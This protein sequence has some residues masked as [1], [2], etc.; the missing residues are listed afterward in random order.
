MQNFIEDHRGQITIV[1][2]LMIFVTILIYIVAVMPILT[3][4]LHN[5]TEDTTSAYYIEDE[6]VRIV[7]KLLPLLILLTIVVSI[8]VYTQPTYP[9]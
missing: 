4:I 6:T 5:A 3:P 8:F 1:A 2:I 9:S 7:L